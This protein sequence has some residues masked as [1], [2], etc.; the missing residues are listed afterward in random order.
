MQLC[1]LRQGNR[2][3]SLTGLSNWVELL[4]FFKDGS[5]LVARDG[6]AQTIVWDTTTLS[7][8]AAFRTGGAG[9]TM[10]DEGLSSGAVSPDGSLLVLGLRDGR[11]AWWD[12]ARG[13]KL[14]DAPAHRS[15]VTAVAFSPDGRLM[16]TS[17]DDEPL[18]LWPA[19]IAGQ[20]TRWRHNRPGC[21]SLAFSSAGNR[22]ATGHGAT[23][24]RV[25]DLGTFREL[26]DLPGEGSLF[27]HAEWSMD[28]NAILTA[29][30]DG[31]CCVWR[32]PS[33]AELDGPERTF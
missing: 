14:A 22:L 3:R 23:G 30:S 17:G 9:V 4:A 7:Q 25:W 19:G 27:R 10:S 26:L 2:V 8:V 6:T 18:A 28:G 12:L 15:H 5:G 13:T 29:T 32:A 21:F 33:F 1:W 16:V 20:P 24:L 11:L 31:R